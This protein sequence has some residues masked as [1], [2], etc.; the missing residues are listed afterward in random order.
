MSMVVWINYAIVAGQFIFIMLAIYMLLS[1]FPNRLHASQWHKRLW[2]WRQRE[3][4]DKLLALLRLKSEELLG[5]ERAILLGG[6]G[7]ELSVLSYCVYRRILI[8][9]F[10]VVFSVLVLG[11]SM[12]IWPFNMRMLIITLLTLAGIIV[13]IWDLYW[14]KLY[15]ELRAVAITSEIYSISHQLLYF[16]DSNLHIHTKLRRCLPYSKL[17]RKDMETLLA[18]W[19]HDPA[20]ALQAFKRKIATPEGTSF[21]ETISALHKQHDNSFYELLRAH[22]RDYKMRLALAK[23]SRKE[24]SSY[25]LFV[26]AGIPILYTFQVFL[27]PWVQEV[28]K[29]MSMMN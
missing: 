8:I 24:T 10:S 12:S 29:L 25:V 2:G 5:D 19:Y 26:I 1:L 3:P 17:L 11:L 6:C 27:Y 22:L 15:R 28:N 23:E 16:E 9:V 14:L 20:A 18:E 21:V 4:S 7:W 13:L